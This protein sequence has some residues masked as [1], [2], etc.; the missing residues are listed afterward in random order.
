MKRHKPA[1]HTWRSLLILLLAVLL[2]PFFASF[3]QNEHPATG[4]PEGPE[5]GKKIFL[6]SC[7][8]CHGQDARGIAGLGKD[9]VDGDFVQQLDDEVL[10]A[11]IERGRSATDSLNT[12]GVPMPPKGGNPTLTRQ[13]ISDIVAYLRSLQ[14]E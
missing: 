7:A 13:D 6:Q 8:A 14:K 11:F 5:E 1:K 4:W 12:T 2:L 3:N 10:I 9:L